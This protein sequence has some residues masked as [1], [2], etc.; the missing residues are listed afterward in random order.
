MAKKPHSI[1]L[2]LTRDSST[3]CIVV[4]SD[5]I[6][7]WGKG[8]QKWS[9]YGLKGERIGNFVVS[10]MFEDAKKY[11]GIKQMKGGGKSIIMVNMII[12]RI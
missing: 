6:P 3:S 2:C 8:S 7:Q 5:G 4:W 11:F 1:E 12:E 9:N 10:L